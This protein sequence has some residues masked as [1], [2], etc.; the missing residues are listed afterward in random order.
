[1]IK[2]TI[3]IC[4]INTSASSSFNCTWIAFNQNQFT[5]ITTYVQAILF[6]FIFE[7]SDDF[8]PDKLVSVDT[9]DDTNSLRYL[10]IRKSRGTAENRHAIRKIR[11]KLEQRKVFML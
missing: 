11:E 4:M 1:M 2:T 9:A 6:N 3:Q 7:P 10:E 5:I 8:N